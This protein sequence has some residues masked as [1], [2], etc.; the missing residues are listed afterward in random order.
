[1]LYR[2]SLNYCVETARQ[3]DGE[4]GM[5]GQRGRG[6]TSWKSTSIFTL[7]ED[8]DSDQGAGRGDHEKCSL[9]VY[10]LIILKVALREFTSGWNVK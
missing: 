10:I 6:E 2:I 8:G 4:E 3:G 5:E 9:S 1:M 7:T